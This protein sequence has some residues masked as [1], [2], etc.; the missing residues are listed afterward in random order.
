MSKYNPHLNMVFGGT[1]VID[2]HDGKLKQW[3]Q[4]EEYKYKDLQRQLDENQEHYALLTIGEAEFFLK[5][6]NEPNLNQSWKNTIYSYSDVIS[7]FSGNIY[8]GAGIIK[9]VDKFK[10]H[11]L[12]AK[13]FIG[14]DGNSYIKISGYDGV[15]KYIIVTKNSM[16]NKKLLSMGVGSKSMINGIVNGA[17]FCVVFSLAYRA[18]ELMLK[19]EYDLVDFFGNLTMD[20]AKLAVSTGVAFGVK[21]AVTSTLLAAGT[22]V[23][24]LSIG[25]FIL[26]IGVAFLLYYI[27]DEFE[28]SQKIIDFIRNKDREV[29]YY[30]PHPDEIFNTWGVYS[31]G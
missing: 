31:R 24:V 30:S 22:S 8:D 15:K 21:S 5:N 3:N 18:V 10:S 17:K 13:E 28:I 16:S 9:I 19:D 25:I 2:E 4:T 11:G 20:A 29:K 6:I 7:S 26:G 27:D 1:M 12:R 23:M 14:K